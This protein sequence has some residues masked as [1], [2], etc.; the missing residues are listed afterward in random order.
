MTNDFPF[1]LDTPI[2]EEIPV[3]KN[4]ITLD[5]KTQKPV[6]S[7][8]YEM[9][10]QTVVYTDPPKR[11]ATCRDGHHSWHL[12]NRHTYEFSCSHCPRKI[13]ISP[14]HHIVEGDKI[15]SKQTG[16]SI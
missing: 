10:Q 13:R 16:A 2:V 9:E 6:F 5:E 4:K 12:V 7:R 11:K 1:K 3:L 14:A 8:V 15:I